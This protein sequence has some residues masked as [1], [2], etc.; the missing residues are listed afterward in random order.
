MI[1]SALSLLA[2]YAA[3]DLTAYVRTG[4]VRPG[5]DDFTLEAFEVHARRVVELFPAF[6]D[7]IATAYNASR[8]T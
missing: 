5:D 7:A 1:W 8:V 6:D 4:W 3:A 2:D